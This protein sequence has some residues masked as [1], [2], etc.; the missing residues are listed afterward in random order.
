MPCRVIDSIDR[1]FEDVMDCSPTVTVCLM[2]ELFLIGIIGE[3][4]V[5]LQAVGES[6][7]VTYYS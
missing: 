3:D 2:N 7:A 6:N 1:L 4:L 5:F